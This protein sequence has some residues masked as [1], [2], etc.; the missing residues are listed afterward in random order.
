MVMATGDGGALVKLMPG[1]AWSAMSYEPGGMF[2]NDAPNVDEPGAIG[3]SG[4]VLMAPAEDVR[5]AVNSRS[6]PGGQWRAGRARRDLSE[7]ERDRLRGGVPGW[8]GV[9]VAPPPW[10]SLTV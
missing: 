9:A 3:A 10:P 5:P 2:W 7:A 1:G 4:S 8:V 6:V